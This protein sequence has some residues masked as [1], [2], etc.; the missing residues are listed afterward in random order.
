MFF[1][2][3][4][5][6]S[7]LALLWANNDWILNDKL[8][9]AGCDRYERSDDMVRRTD[10]RIMHFLKKY[11]KKNAMQVLFQ[12]LTIDITWWGTYQ[13]AVNILWAANQHGEIAKLLGQ[14]QKYLIFIVDCICRTVQRHVQSFRV[15]S[16]FQ[17]RGCM[18]PSG[19][20]LLW[21]KERQEIFKTTGFYYLW[22]MAGVQYES[23]QRQAP[24][25]WWTASWCCL[26]ATVQKQRQMCTL[27]TRSHRG[28]GD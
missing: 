22:G 28:A 17:Q 18:W 1:L 25:Q 27:A 4:V 13:K 15:Q 5:A 26:A 7:H 21:K 6:V 3:P 24:V 8:P 9:T 16:C 10:W 11:N 20:L 23:F 14:S 12:R 2:R 19:S